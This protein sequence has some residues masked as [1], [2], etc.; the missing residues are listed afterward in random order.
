[1]RRLLIGL[2]AI[3]PAVMMVTLLATA[4][5]EAPADE[6]PAKPKHTIKEVMAKAQKGGLWKKVTSGQASSEEKL[7]LLD[8][9]VSLTESKP[10]KG[11]EES[12]HKLTGT[13]LTA[14]IKASVGRE[15]GAAQL[16]AAAGACAACHKLHK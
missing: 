2:V 7:Q 9:Y 16:Q 6:A 5:D 8:L 12:W 10:P 14:A 13:M 1:M 4:Q 15:G 3:V 11:T